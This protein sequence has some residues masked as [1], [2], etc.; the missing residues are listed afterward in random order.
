MRSAVTA[1]MQWT[2]REVTRETRRFYCAALDA[3]AVCGDS[4][5]GVVG[6]RDTHVTIDEGS[7]W[8]VLR[9]RDLSRQQHDVRKHEDALCCDALSR[10]TS[11]IRSISRILILGT[12]ASTYCIF[13]AG[14]SLIT[15]RYSTWDHLCMLHPGKT[16]A[17]ELQPIKS[18]S[19]QSGFKVVSYRDL[20]F[21]QWVLGFKGFKFWG[22]Y[23]SG[24]GD[25][26][27]RL[28]RNY[29]KLYYYFFTF[30]SFQLILILSVY[31]NALL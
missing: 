23:V 13:I 24:F 16:L 20:G 17:S 8:G 15:S 19:R 10:T 9:A 21:Q 18:S 30:Y 5:S 31:V 4:D 29:F 26:G 22:F 6:A 11:L 3:A 12:R 27:F 28:F 7:N 1:R 14:A 2:C 25:L